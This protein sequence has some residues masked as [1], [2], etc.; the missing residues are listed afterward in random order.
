MSFSPFGVAALRERTRFGMPCGHGVLTSGAIT[1]DYVSL[2]TRAVAI[3]V[4]AVFWSWETW[5]PF[6]GKR[7]GRL[8]H[9]VANL[10]LAVVNTLIL[11][12]AFGS[13]TVFV[14]EWAESRQFGLAHMLAFPWPI[15]LL[16]GMVLLDGWMYLWH[17]ANHDIPLLWRFH[18]MHH[19]DNQVDV[20]T[21]TR[22]H[23]GEHVGS[24][25]LRLGLIPL[26]GIEVWTVVV[27]DTLVVAVTQ[28]HHADI[29]IGGWDRPLRWLIVTPYMHKVHHSDWRPE[30]DSNFSTVLSAWDRLAGTFR[31]RAEPKTIRFGLPEFSD[32][33]WQGWWGLWKT[34]FVIVNDELGSASEHAEDQPP[35]G[36]E[37]GHTEH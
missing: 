10:A 26:L 8:R 1:V 32:P 25:L 14:A 27:Y 7:N 4:L 36:G 24:A 31:T 11:A 37:I 23:L 9:A 17:R 15:R 20:T 18:R 28:F 13:A 21:A 34:P 3:V 16:L 22:F 6:F 19:S 35:T 2:P 30:T 33:S 5:R 29:A 12:V